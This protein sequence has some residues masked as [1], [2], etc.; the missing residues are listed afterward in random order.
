MNSYAMHNGHKY[1]PHT[2]HIDHLTHT[3]WDNDRLLL[4]KWVDTSCI[5]TITVTFSVIRF[6]T[7]AALPVTKT[8]GAEF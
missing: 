5:I 2:Q 7:H 8:G 3:V 6:T 4:E 1:T